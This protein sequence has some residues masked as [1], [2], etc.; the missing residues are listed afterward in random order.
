VRDLLLA[1]E[2]ARQIDVR[3]LGGK[4]QG[5]DLAHVL[6]RLENALE[7]LGHLLQRQ[8]LLLLLGIG[9]QQLK[10]DVQPLQPPAPPAPPTPSVLAALHEDDLSGKK[11]KKERTLGTEKRR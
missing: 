7:A 3:R 11:E 1:H 9:L 5:V 4:R 2:P 8:L 10:L 6:A